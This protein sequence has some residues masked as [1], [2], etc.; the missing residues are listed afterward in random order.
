MMGMYDIARI[1]SREELESQGNAMLYLEF[2]DQPNVMKVKICQ[3]EYHKK[4]FR[5]QALC[6]FC[7]LGECGQIAADFKFMGKL[8]RC[9]TDHPSEDQ[10]KSVPW[11]R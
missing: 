7:T 1:M 8:W 9:W 6:C 2:V 11:K 10:R 5:T 3:I 4:L